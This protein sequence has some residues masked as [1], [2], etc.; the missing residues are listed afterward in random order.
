[1]TEIRQ[2]HH[3]PIAAGDARDVKPWRL[4]YWTEPPAWLAEKAAAEETEAVAAD[5]HEADDVKRERNL[6]RVPACVR[7]RPLHLSDL[8]EGILVV[9]VSAFLSESVV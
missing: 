1:M 9:R 8:H 5:V 4:P 7:Q 2:E 3:H 6:Q